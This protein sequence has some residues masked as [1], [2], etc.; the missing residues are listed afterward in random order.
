METCSSKV[1][2]PFLDWTTPDTLT[3]GFP[4]LFQN[5]SVSILLPDGR[6]RPVKNPLANY[7]LHGL[8][9]QFPDRP[10]EN[11]YF[12][13]WLRTCRCPPDEKNDQ[14]KTAHDNYSTLNDH[15]QNGGTYYYDDGGGKQ[16][17][18]QF[19]GWNGMVNSVGQLFT[20]PNLILEPKL[21]GNAWGTFSN[22]K[23]IKDMKQ[24]PGM[25]GATLEASHN[26]MHL[27][28][29]GQGHMVD[30]DFA[31][32][33]PIF[34]LHHCN[35][36]RIYAFWEY[37]YPDFWM[38]AGYTDDN[39]MRHSFKA[40]DGTFTEKKGEKY[41]NNTE[42]SPF[43]KADEDY[44]NSDDVRGL[45]PD[46]RQKYYTYPPI[47]SADGKISVQVDQPATYDQRKT[48]LGVLAKHWQYDP[49]NEVAQ[50]P[51][52][53]KPPFFRLHGGLLGLPET[54]TV[55]ENYRLFTVTITLNPF[56]FN[57]S[58]L[59]EVFLH[60]YPTVVIGAHAVLSR[61]DPNRCSNCVAR[62]DEGSMSVGRIVVPAIFIYGIL[63]AKGLNNENATNEQVV[64]AVKEAFGAR[65]TTPGHQR[66]AVAHPRLPVGA[67]PGDS[68]HPP[69]DAGKVP[70]LAILSAFVSYPRDDPSGAALHVDWQDHGKILGDVW[71]NTNSEAAASA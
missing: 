37:V 62:R 61:V 68:S 4:D 30:N 2:L 34:F 41:D 51:R 23:K 31:A 1:A 12:K 67:E 29:G 57:G 32:F 65:V 10:L 14:D 16:G 44:W 60:D 47:V 54:H 58:H 8:N 35:V 33:D 15:I 55:F 49:P 39:G 28:I 50:L 53:L 46:D 40:T 38:N 45:T 27:I 71:K 70:E 63:E 13:E 24:I 3:D 48:Y 5:D 7:P 25:K 59:L 69:L 6:P 19:P 22:T 52:P 26:W 18:F 64:Q 20:Y 11:A 43:R 9:D 66:L 56:A 17:A 36:D 42:L 21:H